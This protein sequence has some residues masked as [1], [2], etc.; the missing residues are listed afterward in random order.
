MLPSIPEFIFPWL[1]PT[2]G[3][4]VLHLT[5]FLSQD[6]QWFQG[7]LNSKCPVWWR[8][9]HKFWAENCHKTKLALTDVALGLEVTSHCQYGCVLTVGINVA[10]RKVVVSWEPLGAVNTTG[11]WHGGCEVSIPASRSYMPQASRRWP[12]EVSLAMV[13]YSGEDSW[14]LLFF[15]AIFLIYT[16]VYMCISISI[17]V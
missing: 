10:C 3:S 7:K 15:T 14:P 12:G 8:P 4:P 1:K 16:Y 13:L 11:L 5:S 17:S 9:S 2:K 6:F